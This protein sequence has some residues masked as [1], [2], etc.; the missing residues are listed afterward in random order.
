MIEIMR[1]NDPVLIS[2]V[3]SLLKDARISHF[4]ADSNMSILEGS[5]GIIARRVLVDADRE[6][7][8]RKLLKDA[9]L[10]REL[11]G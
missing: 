11:R 4:I 7:E 10:E 5:V 8:A 1:T 6:E 3:E 9:C 2:F